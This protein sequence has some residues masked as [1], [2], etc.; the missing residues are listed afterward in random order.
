MAH[1]T[2]T[3]PASAKAAKASALARCSNGMSSFQTFPIAPT[4]TSCGGS[5]K[6]IWKPGCSGDDVRSS[7]RMGGPRRALADEAAR[8]GADGE[9]GAN[10]RGWREVSA[11]HKLPDASRWQVEFD[12]VNLPQAR[13]RDQ[14]IECCDHDVLSDEA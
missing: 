5:S 4:A 2:F 13:L 10:E 6:R 14:T 11:T 8:Q 12:A 9:E 1:A 7:M 3:K